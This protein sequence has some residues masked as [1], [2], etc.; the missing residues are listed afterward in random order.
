[1][2]NK[3]AIMFVVVMNFLF[4]ISATLECQSQLTWWFAA[5]AFYV[6]VLLRSKKG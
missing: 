1:M 2:S 4:S 3:Y 6:E 5:G